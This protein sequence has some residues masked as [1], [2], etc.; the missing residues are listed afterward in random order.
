MEMNNGKPLVNYIHMINTRSVCA[1]G[2]VCLLAFWPSIKMHLRKT[3]A[4]LFIVVTSGRWVEGHGMGSRET[5]L[6]F[7]VF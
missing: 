6:H 7:I 4:Y 2:N 1:K 5:L 3:H